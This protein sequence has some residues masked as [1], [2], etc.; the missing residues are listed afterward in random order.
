[1]IWDKGRQSGPPRKL[2]AFGPRG[3][4]GGKTG[5]VGSRFLGW[6]AT[7]GGRAKYSRQN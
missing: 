1:M 6:G 7:A 3:S 2:A 5:F 4:L